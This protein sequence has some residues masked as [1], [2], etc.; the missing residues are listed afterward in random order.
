MTRGFELLWTALVCAS[1]GLVS[2]LP[3]QAKWTLDEA[4]M[5]EG[6]S[7]E[8]NHRTRYELLDDPFQTANAGQSRVDVLVH[9]TLLHGRVSLPRG[10]TVGAELMDSRAHFDGDAALNTTIVN[11]VELLRAYVAYEGEQAGGRLA[12]RAGRITMDVGSR[13][14]V[15]RN[16]YRNTINGFTGLDVEWKGGA[17]RDGLVLRGFFTLP[18][19]R[20]PNPQS[21]SARRDRLRDDDV[22]FD[23]ESF[24]VLFWGLY[25]ARD[26]EGVGRGEV[27]FFGL[28]ESD[29]RDRPTRNRQLFTP[30]FRLFRSPARGAFDYTIEAALQAG[31]SRASGGSRQELDHL[32]GFAHLTLGY[33]ADAPWSPR[34][35]FQW[36]Y[37]TGD[38]DPDDGNN[39][40]FDT[41]FG[42]RRFDFGPT[43]L[44][45]A[46]ARTNLH[47]PGLRLQVKPHARVSS[48]VAART[49]WLA[50]KSDA[51]T[52]SGLSDST[53]S[54]GNHIGTQVEI[55]VRWDILPGNLLLESGYAH[56][57]A[58]EYLDNAPGS[59]GSRD[60]DYF[61]TQ[62]VIGF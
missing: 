40:R 62:A 12:A 19:Q 43:S 27:F 34:L 8:L 26:F 45:G 61:Y 33:T 9:R 36:D 39:E 22:V 3:A 46:F 18:V 1:V 35:A 49:F 51:W 28:H 10:F 2:S 4:L 37:A 6:L 44:Y 52:T 41:L 58:G 57:F 23:T 15:A 30:G 14:F 20:E 16:R 11:P 42:A 21:A 53:G 55:R 17:E 7:L 5:P 60:T 56:L 47:S 13:R 31:Q 59:N 54:S 29:A 32:A 48:F 25:A 50:S 24:D 38:G